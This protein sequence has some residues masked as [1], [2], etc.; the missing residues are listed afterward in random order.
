VIAV[1]TGENDDAEFH[2]HPQLQEFEVSLA[3]WRATIAS[4]DRKAGRMGS[5]L[6]LR[7]L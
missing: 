4:N 3:R 7:I 2:W 5:K 6:L 1:R